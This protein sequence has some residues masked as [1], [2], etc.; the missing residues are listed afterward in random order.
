MIAFWL[1]AAYCLAR[2]FD[3]LRRRRYIWAAFGL[4]AGAALLFTTVPTHAVKVDL[5]MPEK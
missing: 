4:L 2:A 5:P 3:D 1:V